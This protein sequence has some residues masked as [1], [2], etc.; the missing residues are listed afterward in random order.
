MNT[1]DITTLEK[2]PTV[3]ILDDIAPWGLL[4]SDIHLIVGPG[5][6]LC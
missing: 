4:P 3:T 1:P 6:L 5:K 2:I